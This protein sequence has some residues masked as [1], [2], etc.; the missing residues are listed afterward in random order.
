MDG[1]VAP[2]SPN[3]PFMLRLGFDLRNDASRLSVA[4]PH[5]FLAA[6]SL[7]LAALF[8]FKRTWRYSLQTI[9]V[10]MTLLAGVLGFA[11]WSI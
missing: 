2:L 6:S 1:P 3:D 5:W 9:L 4:V 11:V 7:G 8:A 10:A